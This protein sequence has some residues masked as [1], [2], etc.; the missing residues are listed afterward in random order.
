ML[1]I[2]SWHLKERINKNKC[3]GAHLQ[4]QAAL[5]ERIEHKE[6]LQVIQVKRTQAT[7]YI[8]GY[9]VAG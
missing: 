2:V 1:K 5:K 8:F 9:S 3:P 7:Q 4:E 6:K